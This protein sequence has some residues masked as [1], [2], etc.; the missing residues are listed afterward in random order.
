M[1][2]LEVIRELYEEMLAL[3]ESERLAELRLR[4][5]IS[6]E[7]REDVLRLLQT[8]PVESFLDTPAAETLAPWLKRTPPA[9]PIPPAIEGY[10]VK[11]VLG[12]GGM[13]VVYA[14]E[15]AYPKRSV[16]IKVGQPNTANAPASRRL[17]YEADL[18]ASLEHPHIAR[19]YG[20]GFIEGKEKATRPFLCME[21]VSG[22]PLDVYRQEQCSN[23]FF[24]FD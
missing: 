19:I 10:E 9:P 6:D 16:A 21:L 22:T 2:S 4:Q 14:A 1:S 17:E 3:P 23:L 11:R 8:D 18:L 13:G 24:H 15:Q 7:T 12:Q 20:A 5:G